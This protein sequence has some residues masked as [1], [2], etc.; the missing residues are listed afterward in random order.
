MGVSYLRVDPLLPQ[1][2]PKQVRSP[3]TVSE[4]PR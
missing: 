2:L 4:A 1:P 3:E